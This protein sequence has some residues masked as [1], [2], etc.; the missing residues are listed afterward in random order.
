MRLILALLAAAGLA[1]PVLAGHASGEP[2]GHVAREGV[3]R[4]MDGTVNAKDYAP[5]QSAQ[6][7]DAADLDGNGSINGQD[8]APGAIRQ[9]Q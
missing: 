5:G 2:P 7:G 6:A 4:N 8:Y 1:S 3:D 9:R